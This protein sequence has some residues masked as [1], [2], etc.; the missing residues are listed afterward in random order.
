[1]PF[2]TS[3]LVVESEHRQNLHELIL[4]AQGVTL[5]RALQDFAAQI[6][7]HNRAL[8]AKADAIPVEARG[9][10]SVDDFC[11]L[12]TR[13]DIDDAISEA[14]RN[15]AA[16][17]QQDAIRNGQEFAPIALPQIDLAAVRV[18]LE[19]DLPELDRTAANRV[20][21]TE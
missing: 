6:E 18:L 5:N 9:G 8:R 11:A 12:Q 13:T 15:L 19:R 16:A 10:I 1:L 3:R 17:R 14:E 21:E 20:Q 7:N 2:L 4:G